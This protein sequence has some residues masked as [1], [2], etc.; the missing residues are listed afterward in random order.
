METKKEFEKVEPLNVPAEATPPV[1]KRDLGDMLDSVNRILNSPII[2]L[3]AAVGNSL[4]NRN[5]HYTG[6]R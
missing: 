2:N 4:L 5:S 3:I 6:R 1:V